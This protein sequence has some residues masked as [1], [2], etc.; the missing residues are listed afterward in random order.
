MGDI[1]KEAL[2]NGYL[3]KI[4]KKSKDVYWLFSLGR[5]MESEGNYLITSHFIFEYFS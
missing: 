1:A 3:G 5:G 4:S 2:E